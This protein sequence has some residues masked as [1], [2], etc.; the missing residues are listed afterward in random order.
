MANQPQAK[1]I[2]LIL[3]NILNPER[4]GD[5]IIEASVK[6]G[7]MPAEIISKVDLLVAAMMKHLRSTGESLAQ[8]AYQLARKIVLDEFDQQDYVKMGK[9]YQKLFNIKIKDDSRIAEMLESY[10]PLDKLALLIGIRPPGLKDD[11]E[12]V[13]GF[14][15]K[16]LSLDVK[17]TVLDIY[18]HRA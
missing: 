4:G 10:S 5:I 13:A 8:E 7:M 16:L 11:Q 3:L 9:N 6:R 15:M 12:L 2:N 17:R 1:L 14:L 18:E